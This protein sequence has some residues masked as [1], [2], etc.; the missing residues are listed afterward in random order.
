MPWWKLNRMNRFQLLIIFLIVVILKVPLVQAQNTSV[1][2]SGSWLKIGITTSGI[3]KIDASRLQKIGWDI[4]AIDPSSL[5]V[6]GNG[7]A[8]LPQ[9]NQVDRPKDLIENAILVEGKSDAILQPTDAIYFYAEG[10]NII[11][12]DSSNA[13]LYHELNIYTDTSYYFLTYGDN[14]GLRIKQKEL[15]PTNGILINSFD[16]YWYHETE[17][18]NLLHSGREWWGDYLGLSPLKIETGIT[19]MVSQSPIVVSLSAIA[20]A[21]IATNLKISGNNQLLG[22]ATFGTVLGQTYSQRSQRFENR[23]KVDLTHAVTY[24]FNVSLSYDNKGQLSAQAFLDYIGLQ[25]KRVLQGYQQQQVYRFLP[26]EHDTLTYQVPNIGSAWQLWDISTFHKPTRIINNGNQQAT[27]T[28]DKGK[29]LRQ[30]IG[31]NF[32][33]VKVPASFQRIKNQDIA[34]NRTVEFLII[35]PKEFELQ[36]NRLADYRQNESG[37]ISAAVTIDQVYNQ[38]ASGKQDIT[39]IRDYVRQLH[40]AGNGSLKYL[41]LFGDATYDY[42]NI[43]KNQ[44]ASQSASWVPV[45]ESRES[46][47]PVYTYSSDDYYGF[48]DENEGEWIESRAGD[49]LLA[50]GIG[51]LPVKTVREAEIVVDKLIHYDAPASKGSW[52]NKIEFVADDGDDEIHQSHADQ[53]SKIIGDDYLTRKIFLDKYPQ[54]NLENGQR[55]PKINEEIKNAINRGTLILNYTGHGGA[56]GWAQEQVLTLSDMLDVRGNNNLPLLVTATCDFGRYDDMSQVSGAELMVLSPRGGAIGALITTRPVYSSTN[57][58]VNSSLYQVI[59]KST[60]GAKRLG[61]IVKETKNKA[62]AGSLNRN[63]TLL[64]DPSMTLIKT[65]RKIN[66]V[67]IPDTLKAFDQVRVSGQVIMALDS[68]L[69]TNFNGIAYLKVYDKESDFTTLGDEGEK[70]TYSDFSSKLFEG[71]VTVLNGEFNAAFIVPKDINPE[72]GIG[73]ISLY[74]IDASRDLDVSDQQPITVGGKGNAATAGSEILIEAFMNDESFK[75]GDKIT[76]NADLFIKITTQNGVNL[77]SNSLKHNIS[78]VLNDTLQIDLNDYFVSDVD[79]HKNGSVYYP[80]ESLPKGVYTVQVKV[81]DTYNNFSNY[82]FKFEVGEGAD[83]QILN[84]KV[85][86]NPFQNYWIFELEHNYEGDDIEV[87]V[88]IMSTSGAMLGVEKWQYFNASPKIKEVVLSPSLTTALNENQLY[89]YSIQIKSLTNN[90]SS[91]RSGKLFKSP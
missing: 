42:K 46:L 17:Q 10:P 24:P 54:I 28:I 36:A 89:I 37:L 83:L 5:K 1:L 44:T 41:L 90:S 7:G 74:A 51:R 49:H 57:F 52:R 78:A 34:K 88:K 12:Y 61:D 32:Q 47:Q 30:F 84:R 45:Y 18:Y 76:P 2:A 19:N 8:M 3:Y 50:I 43:L 29:K 62:L 86:P 60:S 71:R 11:R 85:Y 70:L 68:T 38:F 48:L 16:D 4:S 35:T 26:N 77:L 23:F 22:E 58:L 55:A 69:D 80:F 53:L 73:R 27:F 25:T 20:A 65:F 64:G 75:S 6:F 40:L 15:L 67:G 31:F 14:K 59:K 79:N 13:L 33:Q 66:W 21:Q 39:A 63:F 87:M 56:S 81:W 9:A 72:Y 82:T 91:R